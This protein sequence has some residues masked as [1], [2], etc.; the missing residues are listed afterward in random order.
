MPRE[1]PGYIEGQCIVGR[2]R[3]ALYGTRDAGKKLWQH[4]LAQHVVDIGFVLGISSSCVYHHRSRGLRVLVHGD[5]YASTGT[6]K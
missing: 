3:L 1:D 6:L 2:L 4:C 5:D